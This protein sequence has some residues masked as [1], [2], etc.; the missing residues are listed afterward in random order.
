MPDASESDQSAARPPKV[1]ICY[2]KEDAFAVRKLFERL[3]A[4]GADPWFDLHSL[5]LGDLWENEIEAALPSAD[6]FVVCL[7][8]RFAGSGERQREVRLA[9]KVAERREPGKGGF[10]IPFI[11]EP[12]EL[13]TWCKPLHAG[14]DL[15]KPTS[16]DQLISAIEQHTTTELV[17]PDPDARRVKYLIAGLALPGGADRI[18]AAEALGGIG[19]TAADAVPA[20]IDA[21]RDDDSAVREYAA[22]ALGRMGPA[23]K[24]AVP[25]IAENLKDG[26]DGARLMA[27]IAL[28]EIGPVAANAVPALA[29]TLK[30]EELALCR[31]A[32]DALA[33]IGPAAVPTLTEA[34]K[35]PHS[36]SRA[37][38]AHALGRIGPNAAHAVPALVE[39]LGDEASATRFA[40]AYALGR[41]GPAAAA[42]VPALIEALND[43]EKGVR[44]RAGEALG[45]IGRDT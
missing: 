20:L 24:E 19:P 32:A 2:A 7:S 30:G 26:A 41:I 3:Q 43:K 36:D 11:V 17:P 14:A 1:F 13:P 40:A 42:A 35:Y 31:K 22:S 10:I 8:P 6:V 29:E 38:A 39:A 44:D 4:A 33:Q 12:C 16:F 23:A 15:S 28:S 9:L 27:A 34:L 21:L 25:A 5:T 37:L 18:R 45:Q